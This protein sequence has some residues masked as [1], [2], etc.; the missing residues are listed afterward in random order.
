M[1]NADYA[2]TIHRACPLW[3]NNRDL[4]AWFSYATDAPATWTP[5]LP[6][7]VFRYEKGGGTGG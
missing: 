3:E 6:G 5:V 7:I 4:K 2:R 1:V